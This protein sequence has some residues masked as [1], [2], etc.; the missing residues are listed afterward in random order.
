MILQHFWSKVLA[1]LM[2]SVCMIGVK[3]KAAEQFVSFQPSS[4]V[5]QLKRFSVGVSQNEHSCVLLAASNLMSDIENVTG[6]PASQTA[7]GMEIL[8]G[9]VGVNKQIDQ[10]VKAG[11]LSNLKGKT[12]KY[13]IKTIGNQLVIAGSDKRGTVY[14]IYELSRQMGVSPWYY[15]ADVPIEKH[16]YI[17]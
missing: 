4:D 5:W 1:L 11:V 14:G 13:I 15:W 2:F 6:H 10:W 8:I 7:E 17:Y 12:E 9:T 3:V 16:T